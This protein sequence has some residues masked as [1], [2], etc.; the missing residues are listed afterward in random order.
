M[1]DTRTIDELKDLGSGRAAPEE[2]ARLYHKA[3]AEFATRTL[4][5]W[6]ELEQPTIAQAL[7]VAASLRVEGNMPARSLAVEIEKAC[8]AAL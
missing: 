5:S 1:R 8:R 3:F 7:S 2:V 4:W 6:R